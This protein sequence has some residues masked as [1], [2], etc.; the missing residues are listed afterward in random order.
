VG[1]SCFALGRGHPTA[2]GAPVP[3]PPPSP[4]CCPYPC[5]YCT[6]PPSLPTVAPTRARLGAP[7]ARGSLLSVGFRL[8]LSNASLCSLYVQAAARRPLSP[9]PATGPTLTPP[10]AP[11]RPPR[12]EPRLVPEARPPTRPRAAPLAPPPPGLGAKSAPRSKHAT[13]RKISVSNTLND[14]RPSPGRASPNE[15][16]GAGKR[17]RGGTTAA[18]RRP[19]R[20]C[21]GAGVGAS[22]R[23]CDVRRGVSD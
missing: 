12:D 23:K 7:A 22:S 4:Y 9:R 3:L 5:P 19:R 1:G 6:L 21:S 16:T 18:R 20:R 17:P 8:L 14:A 11:R 13:V 10:P 15:T 2:C